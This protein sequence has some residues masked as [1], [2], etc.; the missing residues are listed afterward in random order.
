MGLTNYFNFSDDDFH[1]KTALERQG[2]TVFLNL[3]IRLSYQNKDDEC[4]D[5]HIIFDN[6]VTKD[7]IENFLGCLDTTSGY[8]N[9]K[10]KALCSTNEFKTATVEL[11]HLRKTLNQESLKLKNRCLIGFLSRGRGNARTSSNYRKL[12]QAAHFLIHSSDNKNNIE[13]DRKFWLERNK[14]LFQSSDAHK[15]SSIGEK[16]T[17]V[18]ADATF[19]GFKQ[20]LCEPAERILIQERN[21]DGSKTPRLIVDHVTYK[22][23]DNKKSKVYFNMGLNSIIGKRGS[24]KSTLLRNLAQK[25]DP[26]EFS[27]RDKKTP[28]DLTNFE[29]SWGDKQK[30]HGTT[31]SPKSVFYIPQG[32]LSALAYDDG[33]RANNR[34]SFLTELLKKNAPF[35]RALRSF[36]DFVVQNKIGIEKLIQKLLAA[37]AIQKETKILLKKQGAIAEINKEIKNKVEL[38]KKYKGTGVTD[39]EVKDYSKSKKKYRG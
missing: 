4:C 38:I 27:Q 14:P 22:T 20:A 13:Q 39:K 36:D 8:V 7:E 29:V 37:D 21:P 5:A 19:D 11:D 26:N 12:E 18:K 3:E 24:G 35:A 9:K 1:L 16:F 28:Y 33:E 10:A 15:L 31:D 23:S 34:D 17:W 30:D 6:A 32:Y 2:V 25:I